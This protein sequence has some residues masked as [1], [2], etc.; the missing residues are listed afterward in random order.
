MTGR[1]DG[2]VAIIT[3]AARGQGEATARLF[4]SAGARVILGD[5][6][7]AEGAAAA[8]AIARASVSRS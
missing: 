3:G 1:L 4:A 5:V 2:R 7:D 8:A 6:D